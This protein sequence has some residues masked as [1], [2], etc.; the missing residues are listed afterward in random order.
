MSLLDATRRQKAY[1][2][3]VMQL[4]SASYS[5]LLCIL[6]HSPNANTGDPPSRSVPEY[7]SL[8]HS[9][10]N[11]NHHGKST[12]WGP[13]PNSLCHSPPSYSLSLLLLSSVTHMKIRLIAESFESHLNYFISPFLHMYLSGTCICTVVNRQRSSVT[14]PFSNLLRIN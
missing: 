14:I 10:S 3:K 11:Y 5:S 4:F 2:P 9:M 6:N 13:C 8:I 12:I 7:L 1:V